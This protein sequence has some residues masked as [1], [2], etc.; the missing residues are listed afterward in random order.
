MMPTTLAS[1]HIY[2]VKSLGGF[3]VAKVRLTDRGLEHDRRWML[4]DPDGRFLSQR[5]CPA[6]ACLHCIP[7]GPG[8]RVTDTRNGSTVDV[9]WSL[10]DG[11]H[12][13]AKVW[14][15]EVELLLG[16]SQLHSWF[17]EALQRPLRLAYM[18]SSTLRIT[19]ARYVEVPVALN[20]AFPALI[21]SQASL[22]D[23]NAR[24]QTP[25]PM[26]RFRPNFVISGGV[27][28]QE[29]HW[30]E[31]S[32]GEEDF[33][34]MKPCSRCVITTTDQRTGERSTEPLRTL[35]TYRSVGNKV[36]FGMYAV[37]AAGGEVRVGDFV[38]SND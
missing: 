15:D 36:H 6:M 34:I 7:Q 17:S 8:F 27:A 25:V 29:D 10:D 5:E 32:I 31:T 3:S 33:H 11:E 12:T 13:L 35:A 22:D 26:D 19:D 21:L 1:I 28:F 14:N 20:D 37:F 38:R 16:D 2:P 4:I 24:L 30:K 9:P 18:P 23:L